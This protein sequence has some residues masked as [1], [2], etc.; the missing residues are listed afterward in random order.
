M[1]RLEISLLGS[2][3]V[4]YDGK[5]ITNSL[6]TRKERALLA[7]LAEESTRSHSREAIAEFFWPDRPE[8]Y[9]RMN[10]RQAL[11]GLRKSFNTEETSVPV[12]QITEESAQVI[13][14]NLLLDTHTFINHIQ[15]TKSHPHDH[16][17][18]CQECIQHLE[19]AAE[20]YHGGFLEDFIIS[21]LIS[22]Q[23]WIVFHRERYFRSMLET[24]QSLS[25]IYALQVNYDQAYKYAW[26]Y[27][28][29]APLEENAHRLLMRILT[30]SG[31]RNAALQ[32][33]QLCKALVEKEL[34]IEPSA[35]TQQL[36]TYIKSGLPIED[37]ETGQ[38]ISSKGSIRPVSNS[39]DPSA[40]LYDPATLLPLR[41]LFM[42]RL[43]Q[44][45]IRME[46]A[47][48]M[49]I[50]FLVSTS[51][52]K[53]L[54]MSVDL[55]RQVVQHFVRRLVGSVREGDTV[56]ILHEDEYA[57]IL[58]EIKDPTIIQQIA[59]KIA[60]VTAAP[61]ITQGQKIEIKT[62]IGASLYPIDG[63]DPHILLNQADFAMRTARLQQSSFYFPPS[64]S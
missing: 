26:R 59:E 6:R 24:L 37:L 11:L 46:R 23:E 57:M 54:D 44:S 52:P 42:D 25:K 5:D 45:I 8:N 12:L 4:L 47:H 55:K 18:T 29:Q 39:P 33:Y 30:L 13:G 35:E 20:L 28:Y 21:D 38:L 49:T 22:F 17:H 53:N 64:S 61:I 63:T 2:F 36:Y 51:Y 15:F 9:A 32:Q 62:V 41:P 16:L 27:A 1:N 31:R 56:A 48:L 58:E 43:K 40:P 3:K 19:K 7:Y 60:R 14:K 50:V 10:L 34:G